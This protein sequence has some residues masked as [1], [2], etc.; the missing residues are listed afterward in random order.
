MKPQGLTPV[1]GGKTVDQAADLVIAFLEGE[2][3]DFD[4]E[5]D[6]QLVGGFHREVLRA[7]R[8]IPWGETAS[9]GHLAALAG[10]PGASRAAAA[11]VAG[12]D[13]ERL[14]SLPRLQKPGSSDTLRQCCTARAGSA[15]APARASTV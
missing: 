8:T 9:Y 11:G 3:H 6:W 7:T 4:L 1:E 14:G 15:C 12:P 13:W 10:P 2:L 5:L